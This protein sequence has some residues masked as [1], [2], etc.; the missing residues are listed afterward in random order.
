MVVLG[1]KSA[2][3]QSHW[4]TSSEYHKYLHKSLCLADVKIF[5]RLNGKLDLLLA[6]EDKSVDH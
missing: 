2:D 5:H 4:D 3:H 6:L 1:L